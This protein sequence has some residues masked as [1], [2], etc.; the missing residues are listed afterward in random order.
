DHVL[1]LL[2]F[3]P[4]L[5]QAAGMSCDFV[6]HPAAT[7]PEV[8]ADDIATLRESLGL[9]ERQRLVCLLPG[10]RLSEIRRLMPVFL[11]TARRLS[12]GRPDLAYVLPLAGAYLAA[13][14]QAAI[15]G[16]GVQVALL[17]PG[18]DAAKRAAFAASAAAIA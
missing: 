2:P 14:V 16:S 17:T 8:P 3:E 11:E 1:A 4:P 7:E 10:S 6:G 13:S 9:G 12:A 5:M 18:D 15:A